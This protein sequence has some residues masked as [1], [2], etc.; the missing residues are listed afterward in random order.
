MASTAATSRVRAGWWKAE[1][2]GPFIPI[3]I[4]SFVWREGTGNWRA[5]RAIRENPPDGG[6]TLFIAR[7]G[8]SAD[9]AAARLSR[10]HR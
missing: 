9:T 10:F 1:E 3:P 6:A 5:I 4:I 7:R 2:G 8:C